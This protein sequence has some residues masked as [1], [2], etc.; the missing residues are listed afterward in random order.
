MHDKHYRSRTRRHPCD[1]LIAGCD[2][3]TCAQVLRLTVAQ[4]VTLLVLC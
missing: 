4:A 2:Q 1:G 3:D